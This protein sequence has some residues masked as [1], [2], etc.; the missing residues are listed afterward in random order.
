MIRSIRSLSISSLAM[1]RLNVSYLLV[2]LTLVIAGCQTD[3]AAMQPDDAAGQVWLPEQR[4]E[5]DQ[6][7]GADQPGGSELRWEPQ[8]AWQPVTSQDA[9]AQSRVLQELLAYSSQRGGT[10]LWVSLRGQPLNRS[11]QAGGETS[12]RLLASGT[13][14]FWGVAAAA[15]IDDGLIRGWDEPVADTLTSWR[16]DPLKSRITVRQLLNFTSGLA[17]GIKQLRG[18][19]SADK[20]ATAV[21]DIP[22]VAEPGIRFTYGPSHLSAFGAFLE[23]KLSA[24]GRDSDPLVYLRTRIFEPIGLSYAGWNRDGA[25]HPI[26]AAGASMSAA[27][28]VK[29]GQL[30]VNRGRVGDRQLVSNEQM[31]ALFQGSAANPAYGLTFWL[32]RSPGIGPGASGGGWERRNGEMSTA[33]GS[34]ANMSP[35]ELV[36][37]L[38]QQEQSGRLSDIPAD[39]LVANADRFDRFADRMEQ[40]AKEG[41]PTAGRRAEQLRELAE[42]GRQLSST[43]STARAD[44]NRGSGTVGAALRQIFPNGPRSMVMAAGAGNQRLYIFPEQKLVIARLG[45]RTR[46]WQDAEFLSLATQLVSDVDQVDQGETEVEAETAAYQEVEF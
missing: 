23:R 40:K 6:A 16:N 22:M 29:F 8:R 42:R 18:S 20:F 10:D 36:A 27:E 32:N 30:I 15:A 3:F 2:L 1:R 35:S 12:K 38:R 21:N 34:G 25:G 13:K 24:A 4:W 9:A 33:G 7:W 26:M 11:N 5:P 14:S 39:I 31:Q 44:Q 41:R 45:E 19:A 37:Y 28:W 43:E 46:D 17:A